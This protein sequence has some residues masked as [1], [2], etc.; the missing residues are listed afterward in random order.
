ME[1]SDPW[2]YYRNSLRGVAVLQ[3]LSVVPI[4]IMFTCGALSGF[5]P[6]CET[7]YCFV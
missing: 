4:L 3:A 7:L 1:D 6:T 5:V 2:A